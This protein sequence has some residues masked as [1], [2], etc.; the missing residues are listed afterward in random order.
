MTIWSVLKLPKIAWPS[1]FKENIFELNL[2]LAYLKD[3]NAA[4]H[5]VDSD[6]FQG[7]DS[8]ICELQDLTLTFTCTVKTWGIC[9]SMHQ[10]S[11]VM[12]H[13]WRVVTR[14]ID[15]NSHYTLNYDSH[16]PLFY[17]IAK[18]G[19]C[20]EHAS[21]CDVWICINLHIPFIVTYFTEWF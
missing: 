5:S 20:V 11:S 15:K 13:R 18:M 3:S 17:Q 1:P 12:T 14:D 9:P 16:Q 7:S 4:A 21:I 19:R 2:E 6:I 10:P 8:S